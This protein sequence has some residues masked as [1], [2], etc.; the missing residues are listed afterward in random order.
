MRLAILTSGVILEPYSLT[1]GIHIASVIY[2]IDDNR[3]GVVD[4]EFPLTTS[5]TI[6]A[7][8]AQ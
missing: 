3:D 6:H 2:E 8:P 4:Y 5:F 7:G 1:P